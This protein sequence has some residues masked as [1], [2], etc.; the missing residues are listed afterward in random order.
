VGREDSQEDI[1]RVEA[2][3]QLIGDEVTLMVDANM[4]W[5]VDQAI[6]MSR[7]MEPYN[8]YWIEEPTIPDDVTGHA[9]IA[10]ATS[11]P[12]A[13][14]ENLYTKH[15]LRRYME[16]GAMAYPEPDVVRVGGITE[17]MRIAALAA[18]YNLPVTSHGVDEIHVHLLAA[19]PNRSFL[20]RH[21]FRLDEYLV[22]PFPLKEGRVEVPDRPGHGVVLDWG[23]LA[24]CRVA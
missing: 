23:R 10:R 2:V 21:A 5:S 7:A 4:A 24:P 12:I 18:S 1:E 19:V 6:R 8:V 11:I 15:E 20:E 14:G 22:E 17:W 13:A 16:C 3:R 9:T